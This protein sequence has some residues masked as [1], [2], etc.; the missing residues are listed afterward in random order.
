MD[1][2]DTKRAQ[3][4]KEV[5]NIW[6]EKNSGAEV[7]FT[8]EKLERIDFSGFVFPGRADFE[9]AILH[10]GVSFAN[11]DFRDVAKFDNANFLRSRSR[12]A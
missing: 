3:E 1:D 5:W 9:G 8:Q 10:E 2:A 4:G 11:T 7:D 12:Y 6:A